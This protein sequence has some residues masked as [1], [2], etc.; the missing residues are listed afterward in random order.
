MDQENIRCSSENTSI[1]IQRGAQIR[2]WKSL[3]L[4]G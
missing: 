4:H 2:T 1:K 3:I